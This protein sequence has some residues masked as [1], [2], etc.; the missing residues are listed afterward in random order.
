MANN[1]TEVLQSLQ[2]IEGFV[3]AAL[4]D[5]D[6]GMTAGAVG[7]T[8][9]FDIELAAAVNTDVYKTKMRAAKTIGLKDGIHDILITLDSQYHLICPVPDNKSLFF[10]LAV[11]RDR[12][13]LAMARIKLQNAGK[14]VSF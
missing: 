4:V 12:A 7:G 9:E 13:N 5:S 3:G 10:Y 1:V 6:S 2:D 14:Q 8:A 11:H